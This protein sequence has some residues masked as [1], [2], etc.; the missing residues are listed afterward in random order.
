MTFFK[1]K[2]AAQFVFDEPCGM[3]TKQSYMQRGAFSVGL[4]IME[5]RKGNESQDVLGKIG[6]KPN[7]CRRKS[8]AVLRGSLCSEKEGSCE[9]RRQPSSGIQRTMR[10]DA[11]RTPAAQV[12]KAQSSPRSFERFTPE[13]KERR[14]SVQD[15][16]E[17]LFWVG[18]QRD[19]K[20]ALRGHT[21]RA[22]FRRSVLS[23][24]HNDHNTHDGQPA[25]SNKDT[26]EY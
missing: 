24:T 10:L 19:L 4:G 8:A 22:N 21:W 9:M 1:C 14:E 15:P 18:R 13:A 25:L 2:N 7:D 26:I 17:Y 3:R 11:E 23:C 6:D 20:Q 12:H 16:P 5:E